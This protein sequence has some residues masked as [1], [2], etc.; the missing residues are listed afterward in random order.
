MDGKPISFFKMQKLK[1]QGI[2]ILTEIH[3]THST[4]QEVFESFISGI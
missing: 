2:S 4:N 3:F 1:L